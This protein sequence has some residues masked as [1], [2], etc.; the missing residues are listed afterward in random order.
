MKTE[1]YLTDA[2]TTQGTP[3]IV[4]N[5]QKMEEARK[6]FSYRA[7]RETTAQPTL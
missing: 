3:K 5:F 6:D 2:T 4:G 7:L 1:I